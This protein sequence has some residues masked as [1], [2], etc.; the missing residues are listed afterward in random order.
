M[1]LHSFPSIAFILFLLLILLASCSQAEAQDPPA[2]AIESYFT[3]L[4]EKDKPALLNLA[5]VAWEEGAQ[6]DSLAYDGVTARL[7]NM[8]C[9]VNGKDGDFTLVSCAG[10]L[11][12]TYF[13][14]DKPISLEDRAYLAVQ[15]GGE[16][17]MCGYR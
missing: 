16:W 11:I 6:T 4:V 3:A 9:K 15:E 2:A 10:N 1:K 7:E 14:E 12:A 8:E 5:C 13:G 17:R